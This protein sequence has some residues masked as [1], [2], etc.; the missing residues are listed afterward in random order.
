VIQ[1]EPSREAVELV[2][3]RVASTVD[4]GRGQFGIQT[5]RG[6]IEVKGTEFVTWVE[7]AGVPEGKTGSSTSPHTLR[8]STVVTVAVAIGVVDCHFGERVETLGPGQHRIFAEEAAEGKTE[9][10][11]D[12]VSETEVALTSAAGQVTLAVLAKPCR[13]HRGAMDLSPGD[14]VTATWVV[15]KGRKWVKDFE[16]KGTVVGVV[17]NLGDRWIEV[18]PQ[19]G[20][21]LKYHAVWVSGPRSNGEK[22][23]PHV[24]ELIRRQKIGTKVELSWILMEGK[25][26]VHIRPAE[27]TQPRPSP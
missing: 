14:P 2:W 11:V 27:E 7:P 21:A 22:F 12:T 17:T 20:R 13:A 26:V 1:G 19:G 18:T 5:A 6:R 25:R 15:R 24:L 4:P 8:A 9:G 10:K 23:N 3:G 16:G